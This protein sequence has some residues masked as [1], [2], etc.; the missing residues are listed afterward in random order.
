MPAFENQLRYASTALSV[1]RF[2]VR[3]ANSLPVAF[4]WIFIFGYF[5]SEGALI[6]DALAH[7]LFLYALSEII[8]MIATPITLRYIAG[9]M[10]RGVVFGTA[11]LGLTYAYIGALALG[12]FPHGIAMIGVLFGL[13]RAFYRVPYTLERAAAS[14]WRPHPVAEFVLALMPLAAGL[15]LSMGLP[16]FSLVFLSSILAL[17]ALGP[18]ALVPT[19][20][21]RFSWS[22]RETFMRFL[23]ESNAG[24][25]FNSMMEGAKGV[26]L[27]VLWPLALFLLGVPTPALLG[28]LV[29]A[30]L[31]LTLLSR[32]RTGMIIIEHRMDGGSFIDEYTA[33][34]EMGASL[35]RAIICC[36]IAAIA[37]LF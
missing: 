34:K 33:L 20:E 25:V 1:H 26:T 29:S 23:H 12:L 21:D 4:L 18:A 19:V 24:I 5:A 32:T 22:Y 27:V 2:L 36:A 10:L 14:D 9:S 3:L 6:G 15:A 31:L 30:T 13:Y 11:L 17:M 8:T 7:T 35:G 37:V 28:A 16:F